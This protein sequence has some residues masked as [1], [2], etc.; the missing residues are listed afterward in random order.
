MGAMGGIDADRLA[1]WVEQSCAAQGV[2]VKVTDVSV[3]SAVSVL[4][5]GALGGSA[6][7]RVSVSTGSPGAISEAPE[8]LDSIDVDLSGTLRARRDHRMVQDGDNDGGLPLQRQG[9]PLAS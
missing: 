9:R 1:A 8:R 6:R 7:K 2:P 5:G 4:L 3:L